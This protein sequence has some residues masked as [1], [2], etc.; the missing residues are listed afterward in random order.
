MLK[1]LIAIRSEVLADLLSSALPQ[2]DIHICHTGNAALTMLE[3]LQ[4]EILI[5]DLLLPVIDG[6]S[7]LCKSSYKPSSILAITTI[8]TDGVLQEAVDVGV[9][10]VLLIPCTIRYITEHLNALVEKAPS[11]EA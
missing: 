10:D 5:L 9:Q 2:Y 1:L 4:P 11:T 3:A 8:A 7:L 6:L